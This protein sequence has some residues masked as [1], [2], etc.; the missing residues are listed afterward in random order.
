MQATTTMLATQRTR[1]SRCKCLLR[2]LTPLDLPPQP[3]RPSRS[4]ILILIIIIATCLWPP[5]HRCVHTGRAITHTSAAT[6]TTT[7]TDT[8]D[9]T[10]IDT[11][12]VN[13]TI[14]THRVHL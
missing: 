8:T 2:L 3:S 10:T 6:T 11:L 13:V 7:T 5:C 9:T 14:A 12:H 1:T 4:V